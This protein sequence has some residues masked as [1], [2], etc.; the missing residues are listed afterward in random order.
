MKKDF[1][2]LKVDGQFKD[3]IKRNGRVVEE[4]PWNHNIVV[5]S[6]TTLI[7]ALIAGKL[8]THKLYWAV[9]SGSEDWDTET[10]IPAP[11]PN[12][13]SLVN[14]IGRKLIEFDSVEFYDA[15]NKPVEDGKMSNRI[16]ITALFGEEE[17]NGDWREFGI[18]GGNAT[19]DLGS[20]IMIDDKRHKHI[21]KTTDTVIERHLILTFNLGSSTEG[22]V[23]EPPTE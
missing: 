11:T 8:P 19:S 9:G 4:T 7:A 16:H 3:I 17:C 22:S 20:G 10:D 2:G 15:A 14:E 21:A 1:A 13:T 18:F 23:E 6:V 5:T 12:E